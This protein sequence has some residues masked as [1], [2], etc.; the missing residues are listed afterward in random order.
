MDVVVGFW[1]KG[2]FVGLLVELGV[3]VVFK[4]GQGSAQVLSHFQLVTLLL[5]K[6]C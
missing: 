6:I 5:L 4:G 1:G 3:E 2:L